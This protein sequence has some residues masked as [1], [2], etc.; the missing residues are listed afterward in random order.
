MALTLAAFASPSAPATATSKLLGLNA[1]AAIWS[2]TMNVT[3]GC[4]V[5]PGE[6]GGGGDGGGG[7]GG[8]EGG[9]YGRGPQSAQSVPYTQLLPMLFESP[10]WQTPLEVHW[11]A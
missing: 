4:H 1:V 6:S 10:S 3:L 8:G 9:Q 5:L 7:D 11:P 2:A